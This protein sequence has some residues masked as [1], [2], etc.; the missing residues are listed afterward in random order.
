MRKAGNRSPFM[1]PVPWPQHPGTRKILTYIAMHAAVMV[2]P[3]GLYGRRDPGPNG[4]QIVSS[5]Q[6]DSKGAKVPV[7]GGKVN[8]RQR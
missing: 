8:G 3:A 1:R 7:D 5:G 6:R 4:R 2:F